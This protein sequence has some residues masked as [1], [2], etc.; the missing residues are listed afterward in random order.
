MPGA[1]KSTVANLL[2]EKNF[3]VIIMG[4]VIREKALEKKLEL[5]DKNLG[6]LM[7]DL[8]REHGNEIIAKLT[9]QKIKKLKDDEKFVVVDGI[10]SYGEF[11]ILKDSD[12]VRLLAIYASSNTRFDHIKLRDRFDS[13]SN[14]E[15]FL[16]R[17]KREIDVGIS[18]AIA[19]ADETIS[20]NDLTIEELRN[21]VDK[22]TM[23]WISEYGNSESKNII[24]I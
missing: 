8:R 23:K 20:N 6:E 2:R 18:E 17:D 7:K 4:D 12:V 19:L 21:S 9:S 1:G 13:P 15:K 3:H 24:T 22:I 10:R 16:Q 5:N 11:K 14:Y